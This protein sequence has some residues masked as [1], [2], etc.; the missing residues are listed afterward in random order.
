MPG[1]E[2]WIEIGKVPAIFGALGC[3]NGRV[4]GEEEQ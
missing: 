4:R 1:F 2:R 3:G